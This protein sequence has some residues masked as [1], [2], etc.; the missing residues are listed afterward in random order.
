ML[1]NRVFIA[2]PVDAGSKYNA[3]KSWNQLVKTGC[4]FRM[5]ID[6]C[7]KKLDMQPKFWLIETLQF[8]TAKSDSYGGFLVNALWQQNSQ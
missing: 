6:R 1:V 8:L 4:G 7:R 5:D 3:S 2:S